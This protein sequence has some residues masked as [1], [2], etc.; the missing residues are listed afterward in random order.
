M[1]GI[2]E[3]VGEAVKG[4]FFKN[5]KPNGMGATMAFGLTAVGMILGWMTGGGLG[6]ALGGL[7]LGGLGV[8]AAAA[9]GLGGGQ[10][11][12]ENPFAAINA[13]NDFTP[14]RTGPKLNI[15]ENSIKLDANGE[16]K[17]AT[18]PVIPNEAVHTNYKSLIEL[19]KKA[20]HEAVIQIENTGYSSTTYAS[21]LSDMINVAEQ[22][23]KK[24]DDLSK[25]DAL[26]ED[27]PVE[28]LNAA[29]ALSRNSEANKNTLL[30]INQE[31]KVMADVISDYAAK[32]MMDM[33]FDPKTATMTSLLDTAERA[34]NEKIKTLRHTEYK[35]ADITVL[36]GFRTGITLGFGED[37]KIASDNIERAIKE[38]DTGN[39]TAMNNIV[40]HNWRN[41]ISPV[42]DYD[43]KSFAESQSSIVDTNVKIAAKNITELN[44]LVQLRERLY[45]F[46]ENMSGGALR[47]INSCK[48][49]EQ[50]LSQY[51]EAS[52]ATTPTPASS[53]VPSTT[54]ADLAAALERSK[55]TKAS[56]NI[57]LVVQT[58]K[59]I[60]APAR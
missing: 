29:A 35:R 57:P 47:T 1:A 42:G 15:S 10:N 49:C 23:S 18:L 9:M 11:S 19:Q 60:S 36:N 56:S 20:D 4:V 13:R 58:P 26:P 34:V 22:A 2:L 51:A 37:N 7:L 24:Y 33:N 53:N 12:E 41:N 52:K 45:D 55:D 25:S 32:N 16:S 8:T 14:A 5:E 6:L 54:E 48:E 46:K 50:L 38:H 40:N 39:Y 44:N 21:K 31:G 30:T 3:D 28:K 43:L 17:T 59:E 27:F